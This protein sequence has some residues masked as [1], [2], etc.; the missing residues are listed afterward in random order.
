[1]SES[2]TAAAAAKASPARELGVTLWLAAIF[3]FFGFIR[4]RLLDFPLERDEGEY[5][6]SGQ[7]LL[8]GMFSYRSLHTM[9]LPGMAMVNALAMLLFGPSARGIHL[10]LMAANFAT[11]LL[12]FQL[13]R[14]LFT[15]SIAVM[16]AATFAMLSL[17]LTVNGFAAHA[18]QFLLLPMTGGLVL[19]LKSLDTGRRA[20]LFASGF[21]LG[22]AVLIKQPGVFFVVFAWLVLVQRCWAVQRSLRAAGSS[23]AILLGGAA[24]PLL[25]T[26]LALAAGG[27]FRSFW[28][29]TVQYAGTYRSGVT[30]Q[31]ALQSLAGGLWNVAL[32]NPLLWLAALGGVFAL[33][34][35]AW[36]KEKRNFLFA[37]LFFSFLAICPALY[38]RPHYF[39]LLLPVVAIL[40]A[41]FVSA[42]PVTRLAGR[43]APAII[44]CLCCSASILQQHVYFFVAAPAALS[45]WAYPQSPF[46][47]APVIADFLSSRS[48][49]E[50]R[51]AVLGS[52]PELLFHA[53]RL[54]ATGFIYMYPL[55]EVQPFAA[56]M[57]DEMVAEITAA[58]PRFIVLVNTN[59][60]SWGFVPGSSH[61]VVEW[62]NRYVNEQYREIAMVDIGPERTRYH[63]DDAAAFQPE[64]PAAVFVYERKR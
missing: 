33:A 35:G 24:T 42:P 22:L 18:T 2:G 30:A 52:E 34:F 11:T 39:V 27:D 38:F 50:D 25:F 60:P 58:K 55:T 15:A 37:F 59:G 49:P 17:A 56:R 7:L 54:S 32:A 3:L 29:W 20:L 4:V 63:W 47:E 46:V 61:A 5:A 16:A 57:Q 45:R 28:F 40:A 8:K 6:Y 51:I 14:R 19:L 53:N 62:A 12:L 9:K 41:A 21:C 23:S 31:V 48:E 1:M 44:F 26:C 43:H 10:G 36:P 64:F 13:T